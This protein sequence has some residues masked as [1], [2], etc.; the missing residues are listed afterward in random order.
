MT[1]RTQRINNQL[2][3]PQ[4]KYCKTKQGPNANPHKQRE[5]QQKKIKQQ[6][7]Y[8]S[9]VPKSW[10]EMDPIGNKL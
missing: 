5:Q 2:S 10:L 8:V 9:L 6:Q 1:F 4:R 7:N 3:F